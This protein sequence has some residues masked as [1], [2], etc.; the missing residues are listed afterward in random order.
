MHLVSPT[1]GLITDKESSRTSLA[2]RTSWR[3]HFEVRGLGLEAQVLGL[4]IYKQSWAPDT[5]KVAQLPL[6]L[7]GKKNSGAAACRYLNKKVAPLPLLAYKTAAAAACRCRYFRKIS[8]EKNDGIQIR[9]PIVKF[10]LYLRKLQ[11]KLLKYWYRLQLALTGLSEK[12]VSRSQFNWL[13]ACSFQ[14]KQ[15]FQNAGW[16]N[17]RF[18]NYFKKLPLE[19]TQGS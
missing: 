12:Q 8:S 15:A 10:Q 18:R 2:S 19:V 1:V 4:E 9:Y 16:S 5:W 17:Q 13:L 6:P 7:F 14:K 3:T 11:F